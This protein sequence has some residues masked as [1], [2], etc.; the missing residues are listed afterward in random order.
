M[1]SGL[2][3]LLFVSL[4]FLMVDGEWKIP[5]VARNT[6]SEVYAK[7][8]MTLGLYPIYKSSLV[9]TRCKRYALHKQCRENSGCRWDHKISQCRAPGLLGLQRYIRDKEDKC[10]GINLR[11]KFFKEELCKKVGECAW[12]AN[13]C[14]LHYFKALENTGEDDSLSGIIKRVVDDRTSFLRAFKMWKERT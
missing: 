1:R 8:L 7:T 10:R 11:F 13:S 5:F 14:E 2:L 6:A 9:S 12:V 4:L 3:V